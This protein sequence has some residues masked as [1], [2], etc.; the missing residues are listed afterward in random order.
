[1]RAVRFRLWSIAVLAILA[2]L[3]SVADAAPQFDET[4]RILLPSKAATTIL[5]WYVPDGNWTTEDWPVSSEEL[6]HLELTLA[7]ALAKA[8]FGSGLPK[9]PSFYRQYMPARWKGLR[10]IVVNGFD[11]TMFEM[12]KSLDKNADLTQWKR[13]LVVSF[14]GGCIQWRAVYIVEEDRFMDLRGHRRGAPV[15]CNAPK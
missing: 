4:K 5:K 10:L 12:E 15:L 11:E 14:G 1:M 7:R 9:P 2:V 8:N 13:E 3:Y 6:N